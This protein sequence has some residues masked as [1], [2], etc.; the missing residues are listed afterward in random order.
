MSNISKEIQLK[1]F[2]KCDLTILILILSNHKIILFVTF[3]MFFDNKLILFDKNFI[4]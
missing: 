4:F 2:L 3:F 1:S